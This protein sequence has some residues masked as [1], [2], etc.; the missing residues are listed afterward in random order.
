M[1]RKDNP[2]F[3]MLCSALAAM[4]TEAEV[5]ALLDDLCTVQ[6]LEALSQRIHVAILLSRGMNYSEINRITG[7]SSA[8]ISRVNKCLNYGSGGYKSALERIAEENINEN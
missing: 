6:E 7:V 8:T 5:S 4:Q 1:F 2:D 3:K